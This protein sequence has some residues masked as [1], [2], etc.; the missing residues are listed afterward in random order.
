[1]SAG[2][3][4]EQPAMREKNSWWAFCL[5]ILLIKLFLLG[6]DPLPKFYMGDSMSY[7]W[8]AISGWIPEDRSYFYGYVIRWVALSS[9]SLTPLLLL[10]AGAGAIT[11]IV[12]GAI[13]LRVFRL[14][15]AVSYMFG[16]I[17]SIDPL[18]LFWE[19]SVMTESVS[20]V[21]YA[22]VVL[23]SLVYVQS[24]QISVLVLVQ[25]LSVFAIGF[26]MS[27]L[28]TVQVMAVLLPIVAFFPRDFARLH[29][30]I[31]SALRAAYSRKELR[32]L[33]LH[34]II[35]VG[36]MFGLQQAYKRA[37]GFLSHR[38]PAYLYGTGLYLLSFWA[39]ALQPEDATDTRLAELI[40]KGDE[41]H[42]RDID[43]RPGERFSHGGLIDTFL[44][45]EGDP[46]KAAEIA[47]ETALRALERNPFAVGWI[48]AETYLE[49]WRAGAIRRYAKMDLGAGYF[50]PPEAETLARLF[51]EIVPQGD[52]NQERRSW[53][54]KYYVRAWP[55]YLVVLL[56]PL[57]LGVIILFQRSGKA[58]SFVLFFHVTALLGSTM[59]FSIFPIVRYLQP[60]SFLTILIFAAGIKVV[61]ERFSKP[62]PA[63]GSAKA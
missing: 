28:V 36:L 32:Q 1:M 9:A 4:L 50:T 21:I 3:G 46:R 51:H 44:K 19:R 56:S 8:T 29:R 54:G 47:K 27:Y 16:F 10:Q 39:P 62:A 20:L 63:L 58:Y 24:R 18:Q 17:C 23:Y 60:I 35:S 12:C 57:L 37:N 2:S 31:V 43:A 6:L 30:S 34:L 52:L 22:F 48:G 61:R 33:F 40:A 45:A 38:E 11:S 55:Y 53:S 42:M 49:F 25:V 59:L 14:S 26:R 5:S 7:L 41:F 13:C 15:R